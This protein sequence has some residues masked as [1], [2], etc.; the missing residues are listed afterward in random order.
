MAKKNKQVIIRNKPRKVKTATRAVVSRLPKQINTPLPQFLRCLVDPFNSTASHIPDPDVTPSGL[1]TS[2]LLITGYPGAQAG[3]STLH[4]TALIM[5]P[6]P[7]NCIDFAAETTAGTGTLT[8]VNATGTLNVQLNNAPNIGS[9]QAASCRVRCT[10]MGVR[11]V[12]QGTELNRA[13]RVFGGNLPANHAPFSVA[14]TGTVLDPFTTVTDNVNFTNSLLRSYMSA[15][16]F[17]TRVPGEGGV[18]FK[19][20]P[21]CTPTYQTYMNDFLP[22][23]AASGSTPQTTTN[24]YYAAPGANGSQS[25]QSVLVVGIDGDITGSATAGGNSY[26]FECIWHWEVV[27]DNDTVVAYDLS[28]SPAHAPTLDYCMN[29]LASMCPGRYVAG[30]SSVGR[31]IQAATSGPSN[32]L[33]LRNSRYPLFPSRR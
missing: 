6:Y 30:G 32:Q 13:G 23:I 17:E 33:V 10:G 31:N 1:V 18:E 9:F 7:R 24:S 3:T 27:P 8:G 29:S 20:K 2:R 22:S 14:G 5:Y 12:Y 26:A 15:D 21:A 4:S 28:P 11:V 19:W 25:G 16:L